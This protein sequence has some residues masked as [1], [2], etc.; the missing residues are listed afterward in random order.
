[1]SIFGKA[2]TNGKLQTKLKMN[3]CQ[4]TVGINIMKTLIYILTFFL[5]TELFAQTKKAEDFGYRHIQ[6]TFNGDKVD[7]LIKSK[8]EKS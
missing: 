1:M 3:S 8:K 6:T 4:Q 2:W 5:T 7:I